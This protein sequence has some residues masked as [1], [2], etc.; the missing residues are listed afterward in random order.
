M[1][2]KNLLNVVSAAMSG[3][4]C[5]DSNTHHLLFKDGKLF[6]W[7]AAIVV[8]AQLPSDAKHLTG[9]VNGDDLIKFLTKLNRSD[10]KVACHTTEWVFTEGSMYAELVTCP[11]TSISDKIN[12]MVSDTLTWQDL[13][14][15]FYHGL[16]ICDI[17]NN[18]IKKTQGVFFGKRVM[19]ST[20]NI[21]VNR[22]ILDKPI[23]GNVWL[24][25]FSVGELKRVGKTFTEYALSKRWVHFRNKMDDNGV[26]LEFICSRLDDSLYEHETYASF[27]DKADDCTV[28]SG[29]LPDITKALSIASCFDNYIEFKD[30]SVFNNIIN[31]KFSNDG[32]EVFSERDSS[33]SYREKFDCAIPKLKE[34]L[35]IRVTGSFLLGACAYSR[36]FMLAQV[37]KKTVIRFTGDDFDSIVLTV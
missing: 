24:S 37:G 12:K 29:E 15:N 21:R 17:P 33:G 11:D 5:G 35:T 16:T 8:S 1:N 32:V 14:T 6:S 18:N 31:L 30:D 36:K 13:P 22:V 20:D 19:V 3:I 26:Q 23:D 4:K 7:S 2:I 27:I 28:A 10:V 9:V 34:P 25:Q